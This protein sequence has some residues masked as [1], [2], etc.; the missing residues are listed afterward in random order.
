MEG[1]DIVAPCVGAWIET[2]YT[3][4]AITAQIVAPCVGAW[5]ET[6]LITVISTR[7]ESL[8]AWERGLKLLFWDYFSFGFP[9]APC[10]GAWIETECT[11]KFITTGLVAPCV[12]AWIET[13]DGDN[14]R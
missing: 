11:A 8:P 13:P 1:P 2:S 6:L 4:G 5:I 12:G 3:K 7:F 9:V 10:V 14:D